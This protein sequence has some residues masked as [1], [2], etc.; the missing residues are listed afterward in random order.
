GALGFVIGL[1]SVYVFSQVVLDVNWATQLDDM[2][3]ESL[4]ISQEITKSVGF[5]QTEEE[6]ERVKAIVFQIKD[7]IPVGFV[8]VATFVAFVSQWISYKVINR[9]EGKKFIFPPFRNLVFP[10]ALIWIYFIALILTFVDIDKDNMFYLATQNIYMLVG[11]LI[12]LQG[13]S[14]IFF[15]THIKEKS[16]ALPIISVILTVL[17]PLFFIYIVRV[18]GIIDIGL[19]LRERMKKEGN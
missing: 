18:I 9:L 8:I 4:E 14:F 1:A 6:I 13:L 16:K 10:M 11:L 17:F 3:H 2:L 15:Y 5:E 12:A 19:S 7:L